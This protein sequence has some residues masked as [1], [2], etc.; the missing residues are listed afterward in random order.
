MVE[1]ARFTKYLCWRALAMW[2]PGI[3]QPSR[4]PGDT[5]LE[6]ELQKIT[7]S[8]RS[9]ALARSE[10]HT[11]ELQSRPHLVCRLLLEKK[12]H[13]QPCGELISSYFYH[14]A[15]LPVQIVRF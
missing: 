11:S 1:V 8:E 6:N 4:R 13:I 2:R 12:N 9:K 5:V 7:L 15:F 14:L 3:I 10:E